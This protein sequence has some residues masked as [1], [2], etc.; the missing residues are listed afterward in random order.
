MISISNFLL[1]MVN[2]LSHQPVRVLARQEKKI[3]L[4]V[5]LFSRKKFDMQ[6]SEV[7]NEISENNNWLSVFF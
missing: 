1:C 3:V 7:V 4:S 6:L 5:N 2:N